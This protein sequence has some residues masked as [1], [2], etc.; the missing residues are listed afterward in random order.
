M[1]SAGDID[2]AVFDL[3]RL[4]AA[5]T[6]VFGSDI[7]RFQLLPPLS[8]SRV[9]DFETNYGIVLPKEYREFLLRAGS[10]GA[11]PF[12]GLFAFH[13]MDDGFV[14]RPWVANGDFVG[15]LN[16]PFPF[17]G[18]WNDLTG[19][20]ADDLMDTDEEEYERQMDS[21]EGRYWGPLDGALPLCNCGC[22]LRQWL[23]ITGSE[24]GCVW[25]DK[26]ADYKGMYPLKGPNSDRVSFMSWYRDWLDKS[27][28][29][30][31]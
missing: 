21:F 2:K 23:V 5:G 25:G 11:G 9:R 29:H 28:E 17:T 8:E 18:Q 14:D 16:T 4:A 24:A 15:S 3:A 19:Q 10:G 30:L 1:S 20:P 31:K 7:H 12:Y 26:R 6:K 13:H 27:L 22:A